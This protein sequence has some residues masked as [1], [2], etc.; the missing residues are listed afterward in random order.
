SPHPIPILF[1]YTTLFR[2]YPLTL[3]RDTKALVVCTLMPWSIL[4][5]RCRLGYTMP[6]PMLQTML[7]IASL[8][9]CSPYAVLPSQ[10]QDGPQERSEEHTSELQSPCNLVC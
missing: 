8:P 6:Q 2:S 9:W 10:V 4:V 5:V 1:P 3:L 7:P